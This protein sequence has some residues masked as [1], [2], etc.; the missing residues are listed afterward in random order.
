[1]KIRSQHL[2]TMEIAFQ[3]I[4]TPRISS[5]INFLLFYILF[6]SQFQTIVKLIFHHELSN[7][8][9]LIT[10]IS[11]PLIQA[12]IT[13][14]NSSQWTTPKNH[15]T[16]QFVLKQF[17]IGYKLLLNSELGYKFCFDK[18]NDKNLS[19]QQ[20]LNNRS[21]FAYSLLCVRFMLKAQYEVVLLQ[22]NAI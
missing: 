12:L 16:R 19:D 8:F 6:S 3:N 13:E 21:A 7:Q 22:G 4:L 15:F 11:Y 20:L 5:P 18:I 2:F 1:M 10:I 9:H 14:N 17:L